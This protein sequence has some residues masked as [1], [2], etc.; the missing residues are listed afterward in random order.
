VST[1]IEKIKTKPLTQVTNV[2]ELLWN[3]A[4]KTQLQQVAAAHMKPERMM[5][6]MANAI[7]TTPKLGDCDPMSLLGGLMTCAGLGLEPNTIMGHAYLIPFRNNRKNITEVQLVVGYKGLIDLARRSGHITSIS[8]N[9]H[10]SDDEVWEY[11]EGTEARLRHIP[12]AQEGDK[13]HAYAIAKFRDGGH[14]Y[15]VLPWAKVM[16]IRDGSQG[17]QTAVKFGATDRN[18]WKSHEDEMAKKTAIRAL[19]KYL[20]LSVEFRDALTVDGGKA[21]FA[22]FAINPAD[23]LDATPDD[24]DGRT[25]DGEATDLDA[26]QD[27]DQG[28]DQKANDAKA[29]EEPTPVQKQAKPAAAEQKPQPEKKPDPE[30]AERDMAEEASAGLIQRILDDLAEADSADDA[31]AVMSLWQDQIATLSE[32][33]QADINTAVANV[34]RGGE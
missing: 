21:D 15:V 25:I 24:E 3:D 5:R 12:G 11:E 30:T 7:R 26:D 17:W 32:Q 1:A 33:A 18:P 10:Y 2:K 19:A 31:D 34:G 6:L 14:A 20:P 29:E 13:R 27:E 23:Q 16:K 8:A 4:A 22:A 9:I 28:G